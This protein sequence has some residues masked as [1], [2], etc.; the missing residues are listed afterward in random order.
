MPSK[1]FAKIQSPNLLLPECGARS[2][3]QDLM[4]ISFRSLAMIRV[5]LGGHSAL[6]PPLPIPNRVVKRGRADDSVHSA[7]ESRS[8]PG[9]L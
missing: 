9:T 6:D 1:V 7:C 8:L 4:V 3:S 2:D 5:T